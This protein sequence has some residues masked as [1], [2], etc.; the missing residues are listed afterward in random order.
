MRPLCF[1]VLIALCLLLP[2]PVDLSATPTEE[3]Q[4]D[5]QV[6]AAG[7]G[8]TTTETPYEDFADYDERIRREIFGDEDQVE[9]ASGDDDDDDESLTGTE[10]GEGGTEESQETELVDPAAL[11]DDVVATN[12]SLAINGTADSVNGTATNATSTAAPK[13]PPKRAVCRPRTAQNDSLEVEIAEPVVAVVNGSFFLD[14]LSEQVDSN[15]TNRTTPAQCSLAFFYASWCPFSARAAPHFNGLARLFPDVKLFAIDTSDYHTINTQFG[16]MA[17]PTLILF[18]NGKAVAKY[19]QSEFRLENFAKHLT[20]FTSLEARAGLPMNLTEADMEG[21]VPTKEVPVT[22]HYLYLAYIF[23]LLVAL[24][25][26]TK[27]SY[28]MR[29]VESIRNTWREAEI[30]HEHQD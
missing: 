11:P 29:F 18:H 1:I 8:D 19:N 22:D 24:R 14:S 15:V 27:S 25:H 2:Y 4:H 20:M 13:Q 6:E 7:T 21:P 10:E 12:D 9:A 17:L 30:Q 16:I 23:T 5:G 26:F 3:M 28:F